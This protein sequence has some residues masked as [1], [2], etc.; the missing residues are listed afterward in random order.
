MADESD[1]HFEPA[2]DSSLPEESHIRALLE[3]MLETGSGP[4]Q[5]SG[6]DHNL[7]RVL[8]KRLRRARETEAQ[9]E[10]LFPS[11][12]TG[13]DSKWRA[14]LEGRRAD[15]P[16]P[17]IPGYE[18]N[19][20]IGTG[21]M[22]VVY[23]AKHLQLHRWVAI[24]MV[25]HGAYASREKMECLL[26][27]AQDV[28]A[29]RHPNIVQVYDVG[30]HDGFP[31]F[32]M[33]LLD[34]GDLAR[35]LQ[36]KPLAAREA[37]ELIRVLAGAVHAAHL[38]GIV[39]R[40][41]KPGNILLDTDETPKITDFSLATRLERDLTIMTQ[42]R[43]AGTPS[44]MAPEQAAGDPTAIRPAVDIYSLGAILYELLTG[45]PP[46]KADTSTETRRQVI[47]DE[48]A[49]PSRLNS[50]VPRDLQTICL[51]CLQ[52][53]PARRYTTAAD[54]AD[55]MQRFV[56]GE[57][58]LARPVGA[59]EK[60]LKWCRRRPS[61][62]FAIAVSVV[63]MAGAVSGGIWLQQLEHARDTQEAVRRESARASIEAALPSLSQF[64]KSKQ[65]V[66]AVGLLRTSQAQLGDAQ[67]PELA[68]RLAAIEESFEVSRELYRIRENF[69]SFDSAGYT[70]APAREAYSSLFSR[71]GIGS[72][73]GVEVAAGRVK[74]SP[75]REEL[76]IAL[77]LAAFAE[78][79]GGS[80]SE[81]DR[82]L[83]VGRAASPDPWQDRFR[84][85]AGWGD[86]GYQL[87]LIKDALHAEPLPPSHQLFLLCVIAAGK[88]DDRDVILDVLREAQ[89]RDPTD[90]WVTLALADA[91]RR[92]GNP[93]A[94]QF[95]RTATALQP[96][97]VVAW[98]M[99][100]WTLTANGNPQGAVAP[101]KKAI[102][103]RPEYSLSLQYL[104][105]ALA[106]D[107]QW[108]DALAAAREFSAAHPEVE[109]PAQT[110]GMILEYAARSAATKR[111][112]ATAG[113]FYSQL[114]QGYPP[115]TD[116]LFEFAAVSLLDGD[117][118]GYRDVCEVMLA[119]CES[120]DLRRFLVARACTFAA[121]S[122]QELTRAIDLS[123]PELDQYADHHWSLT[124]RAA[125]L[126]R[127][128]RYGDAISVLQQSVS[129]TSQPG[130]HVV[131]W[132]W[133]ARAH[134]ALG[135]HDDARMWLGKSAE[136]L[137]QS[138]TR[139][140][141]IHLHDWLEAQIL[142]RE[143]ESELAR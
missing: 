64:V 106:R 93:E 45:R 1:R 124:Q 57:P 80:T 39:H 86:T 110:M 12:H 10:A 22:G 99:L 70:H 51:K 40:D 109:V 71:A 101:L 16:L 15:G 33:E 59:V 31:Y 119:R 32:A 129:S 133:L 140:E 42:A 4:E 103:L 134:L 73:V 35:K 29:L 90:V 44:Y 84:D 139:P 13:G 135:E 28:A 66:D 112:W 74:E 82:L 125:L 87:G 36:G 68:H 18:V 62:T 34:G 77:D 30:Q 19:G 2:D 20:V 11:P 50:R 14:S 27:E 5:V 38:G 63:A 52:K 128:G 8:R 76:L 114:H 26:R 65:W 7:E 117:I 118:A 111:E 142:R 46:F 48:P 61:T 123:M 41:L 69:L 126:C 120:A 95:Y 116:F 79:A 24:K 85:P 49:P 78:Q 96:T 60:T 97:N 23:R 43:Q 143:V 9:L 47:T 58:I 55:D 21:G 17:E 122:D 121:V 25:L 92:D 137:D 56:S 113:E 141:G 53:D 138:V 132:A 83:A 37:A 67:S 98:C 115:H 72:D 54:L 130:H 107:D 127:Q 88:H 75:L 6:G 3:E 94:L 81:R 136:W 105:D 91:L 104:L 108:E 89:L 102:E 100:G 131:A